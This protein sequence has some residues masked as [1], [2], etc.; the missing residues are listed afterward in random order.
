M[1][2]H[3]HGTTIHAKG[4]LRIKAGPQRDQLVHRL[5]AA[6]LVGRD[7]DKSE[8]V[9]HRD[10]NRKNCHWKNLIVMGSRDHGWVSAKQS[11]YMRQKDAVEKRE[12]DE[13]MKGVAEEFVD[14]VAA[15]HAD[16]VP[17]ETTREDGELQVEWEARRASSTNPNGL[18]P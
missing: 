16:G 17:W 3:K 14:E 6:A 7:L 15:A 11:W 9:H 13:Y 5:I 8:E 12:W 2:K 10:G 1:S 4:Y 18:V